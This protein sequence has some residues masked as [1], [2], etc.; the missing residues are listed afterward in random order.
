ME[1]L[2]KISLRNSHHGKSIWDR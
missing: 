1:K 2:H